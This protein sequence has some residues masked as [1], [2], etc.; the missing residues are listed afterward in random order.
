MYSRNSFGSYYPVNSTVHRLNSVVKLINFLLAILLLTLTNSMPINVFVFALVLILALL[1]YVPFRYFA[2]TFWSMRYI[3]IIIVFVCAYFRLN[4]QESLIYVLKLVSVVEYLNVFAYTTSPSE[5]VYAIEKF[6]SFFNFLCLPVSKIA[7]KLNAMLRYIPL[8]LVVENKALKA[9]ASRGIDYYHSNYFGRTNALMSL[10]SNIGRLTNRKN[11]D[12]TFAS[13]LR[14][15]NIKK[16]R[17]NYR[18]NKIGFYDV[19]FTLFHLILLYA[20]LVE[21]GVL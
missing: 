17:T 20:Y 3:Y 5:S 4:I 19:F 10:Y 15:F 8:V 16:Y 12:I 2:N 18:T 11:K 21:R 14:L 1:S 13:E 6:L 9:Q 7:F